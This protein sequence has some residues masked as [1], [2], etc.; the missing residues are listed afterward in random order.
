MEKSFH[1]SQTLVTGFSQK[2]SL[3]PVSLIYI[4]SPAKGYQKDVLPKQTVSI[5]LNNK[6]VL[7]IY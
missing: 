6:K 3:D 5:K 4:L 1:S 7:P 2:K